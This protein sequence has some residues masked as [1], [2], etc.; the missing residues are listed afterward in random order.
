LEMD[1]I[2]K[3]NFDTN[4]SSHQNSQTVVIKLC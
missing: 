4:S 3:T 2:L 1:L